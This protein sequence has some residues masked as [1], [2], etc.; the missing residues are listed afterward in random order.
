MFS[1]LF[2][3]WIAIQVP[4][5][6]SQTKMIWRDYGKNHPAAQEKTA[7]FLLPSRSKTAQ[8]AIP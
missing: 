6:A 8:E 1:L 5:S 3:F 4:D 2:D 7:F